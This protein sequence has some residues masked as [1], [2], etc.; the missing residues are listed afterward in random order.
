MYA[1]VPTTVPRSVNRAAVV[2]LRGREIGPSDGHFF[3]LGLGFLLLQAKSI[4]DCSLYFGATWLVTTIVI[5]GVLLMVLAAN[6]VALRLARFRAAFYVPLFASLLLLALTDRQWV[7]SLPYGVRLAW[8]L[9]VVPLPIFFAGL[10]FSTTFRDAA[11]PSAVFGANLI[12]A[13]IGGFCEYLGM[14]T[15]T[16]VLW[17]VVIGAYCASFLCVRFVRRTPTRAPVTA[18]SPTAA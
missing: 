7:L 15:G 6:L 1:G 11:N 10:I 9:L 5:T 13:T 17:W 4:G 18:L 14:A 3:F 2:A 8:A 16:H 12:G